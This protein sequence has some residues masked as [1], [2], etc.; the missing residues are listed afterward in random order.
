MPPMTRL[1]PQLD[2]YI[3]RLSTVSHALIDLLVLPTRPSFAGGT[4][5]PRR[6]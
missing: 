1:Y 2:S 5:Q 6:T 4:K 3:G